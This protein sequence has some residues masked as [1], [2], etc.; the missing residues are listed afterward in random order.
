MTLD[1]LKTLIDRW[2]DSR[3][4]AADIRE[5]LQAVAEVDPFLVLILDGPRMRLAL[6]MKDAWAFESSS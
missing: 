1:E 6:A 2:E 5:T 3:C 4:T